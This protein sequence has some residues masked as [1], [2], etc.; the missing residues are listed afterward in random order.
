VR[1][2]AR[3]G[4]PDWTT[5]AK[6]LI[7]YFRGSPEMQANGIYERRLRAWLIVHIHQYQAITLKE[8]I[9]LG[10]EV[11]G[12]SPVTI[13]RYIAKMTSMYGPLAEDQD[14]FDEPTLVLK[15]LPLI[16]LPYPI[17]QRRNASHTTHRPKEAQ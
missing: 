10:A 13:T 7:P 17:P 9:N 11:V 8:A 2:T 3:D 1:E 14:L 5:L 6:D 12:A 15:P 16:P 4:D